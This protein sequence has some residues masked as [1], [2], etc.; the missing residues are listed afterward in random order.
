MVTILI[1]TIFRGAALIKG[2]ALIWGPMLI[3]GQKF[4]HRLVKERLDGNCWDGV[5]YFFYMRFLSGIWKYSTINTIF[6]T[7]YGSVTTELHIFSILK[8]VSSWQWALFTFKFL[9]VLRISY[10]LNLIV[11]SHKSV[12]K[13]ILLSVAGILSLHEKCPNAE[14]F[15]V[16]IQQKT[17]FTQLLRSKEV[18]E[19]V[20]ILVKS[21]SKL[22]HT[23]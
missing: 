13:M 11:F 20:C 3:R 15:L 14:F 12:L 8:V 22:W 10:S 6:K 7:N 4:N 21:D 9:L 1:S 18:I 2:E 17:L 23:L 16:R 19:K 5:Y